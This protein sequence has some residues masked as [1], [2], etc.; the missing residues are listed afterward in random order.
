MQETLYRQKVVVKSFHRDIVAQ[1]VS[2]QVPQ[3]MRKMV[4]IHRPNL[5]LVIG[6]VLDPV[7]GPLIVTELLEQTIKSAYED[8]LLEE[9]SKLLIL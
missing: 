6:A 4:Q 5:L 9:H 8:Q 1:F 3:E 7:A 2:D